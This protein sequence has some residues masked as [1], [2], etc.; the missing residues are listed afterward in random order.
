MSYMY[1][2]VMKNSKNV[3]CAD[4]QQERLIKIGWIVGFVDGEGCF[5]INF[6]KQPDRLETNR[7][8]K[9]YKTGYQIGY[10]F[11]V[12]QGE[13]SLD[14][15]ESIKKFFGVGNLYLN[16]RYDNH[17]EHIYRYCVRKRSDLIDIIIPFFQQYELQTSKKSNFELFLRCMEEIKLNNHLKKEGLLKILK[18]SELMNHKK[19][20][21]EIIRIL[22]NQTSD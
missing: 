2:E 21:S 17:K 11:S 13:S 8:R 9:G 5:S 14:S 18:I 1:D 15:L 20:K 10:E 3:S 16:K 19:S 22:R 6:V 4:D 12:T 7:L